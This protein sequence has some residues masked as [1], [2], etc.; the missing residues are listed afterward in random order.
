MTKK[1]DKQVTKLTVSEIKRRVMKA[2]EQAS[3]KVIYPM[4]INH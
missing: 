2:R 3:G 1:E 4:T